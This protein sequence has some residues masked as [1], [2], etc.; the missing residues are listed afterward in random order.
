MD[1][2][3]DSTYD[4]KVTTPALRVLRKIMSKV[5][6]SCSDLYISKQ[7]AMPSLCVINELSVIDNI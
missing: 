3:T 4:I 6:A 2:L 7:E 5:V 1:E